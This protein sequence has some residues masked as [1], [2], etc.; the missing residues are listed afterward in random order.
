MCTYPKG[1]LP[2]VFFPNKQCLKLKC[3]KSWQKVSQSINTL[4]SHSGAFSEKICKM[5]AMHPMS[6]N[7]QFLQRHEI[8]G[9]PSHSWTPRQHTS[10]DFGWLSGDAVKH[11]EM[12][13][14]WV[15][16]KL[17]WRLNAWTSCCTLFK[18]Q[19]LL[20]KYKSQIIIYIHFMPISGAFCLCPLFWC[21]C[22]FSQHKDLAWNWWLD[23]LDAKPSMVC[24]VNTEVRT[25]PT[26]RT[27]LVAFKDLLLVVVTPSLLQHRCLRF[28]GNRIPWK[29]NSHPTNLVLVR[30]LP[31]LSSSAC[32]S[33][34][35]YKGKQTPWEISKII[36]NAWA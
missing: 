5:Q 26:K 7:H 16:K 1:L 32:F 6:N 14:S 11:K 2:A 27:K 30:R 35:T 22:D 15:P 10:D 13:V 4:T 8:S 23:E 34:T 25:S 36:Q 31:R 29:C 20:T 9:P 3:S 28:L 12:D 18:Q 17:A 33:C 21:V 24:E 19:R